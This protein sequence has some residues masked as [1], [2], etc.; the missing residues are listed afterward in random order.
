MVIMKSDFKAN[1]LSHIRIIAAHAGTG[2]SYLAQLHPEKYND[3]VCMPYKYHLAEDFD[4]SENESCKADPDYDLNWDYP[5]NYVEAIKDALSKTRDTLIIPPDPRVLHLLKNEEIPY[6]LCYPE[7]T[8]EAKE[9]YRKRYVA[10][11]NTE[12]FLRIFIDGWENF[13]NVFKMDDYGV[14]IVM[15]PS[16][17]LADVIEP[18]KA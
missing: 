17:Y 15:K 5:D 8:D 14:H 9:E 16:D 7:N 12:E 10:R 6:L 4:A 2:K 1:F 18:G 11:G 3:F 13:M